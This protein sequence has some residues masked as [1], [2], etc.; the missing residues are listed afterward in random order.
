MDPVNLSVAGLPNGAT[1][2]WNPSHTVPGPELQYGAPDRDRSQRP[3][4]KLR[5]DDHR[6]RHGRGQYRLSVRGGD[7]DRGEDQGLPDRRQ[8]RFSARA[9]EEGS[10]QPGVDQSIWLQ[11]A[12]HEPG[13]CGRGRARAAPAAAATQNFAVTQIPAARYPITLPAGQTRTLGQLG[14]ADGDKPQVGMLNQPWNQDACK[15]AAISLD[16]S[17]SARK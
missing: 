9:G 15:N 2:S 11:P 10:P 3:D 5:P 14:V 4:R 8:S 1:A 12:D 6:L 16:Y 17:G 7:A 13:G